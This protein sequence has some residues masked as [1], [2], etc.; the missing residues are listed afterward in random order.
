[1]VLIFPVQIP[2][3]VALLV[4]AAGYAALSGGLVHGLAAT[5]IAWG[6][7]A[8][9]WLRPGRTPDVWPVDAAGPIAVGLALAAGVAL[10]AWHR[11]RL[12]QAREEA[13]SA[14]A[15]SHEILERITD[16]YLAL[17]REWRIVNVNARGAAFVDRQRE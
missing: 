7:L 8:Y 17:D 1:A 14:G 13:A 16:G 4:L 6:T 2:V 9:E 10:A 5:A 11:H 3:A 12:L 15:E